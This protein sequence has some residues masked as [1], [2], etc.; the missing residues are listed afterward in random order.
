M[1]LPAFTRIR[2]ATCG[3]ELGRAFAG[4][5]MRRKRL[6]I[7]AR[8]KAWLATQYFQFQRTIKGIYGSVPIKDFRS[9]LLLKTPSR[10]MMQRMDYKVL[11]LLSLIGRAQ[12]LK[13]KM[14]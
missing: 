10:T 13:A 2:E 8:N 4:L 12:L 7:T 5:T 6:L 14:V 3:L 11:C 1:M 9:F